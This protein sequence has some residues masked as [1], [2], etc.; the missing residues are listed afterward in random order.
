MS[1]V[2]DIKET[3][4]RY[5][6]QQRKDLKD[7]INGEVDPE[8]GKSLAYTF[9]AWAGVPDMSPENAPCAKYVAFLNAT[10]YERVV[11]SYFGMWDDYFETQ[12]QSI[13]EPNPR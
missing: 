4:K 9:M 3:Q 11:K 7:W 8:T 6:A 2:Q 10:G 1:Y 12:L 5:T 13:P